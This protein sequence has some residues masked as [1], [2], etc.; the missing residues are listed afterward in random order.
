MQISLKKNIWEA[1]SSA[2]VKWACVNICWLTLKSP[3][4]LGLGTH[5]RS[6]T[7]GA[8]TCYFS[9][10]RC[11]PGLYEQ[12]AEFRNG[13]QVLWSVDMDI[14]STWLLGQIPNSPY[15]WVKSCLLGTWGCA[16]YLLSAVRSLLY[17]RSRD[18]LVKVQEMWNMS[19]LPV[20]PFILCVWF[21]LCYPHMKS[22]RILERKLS[23]FETELFQGIWVI[24]WFIFRLYRA[25]LAGGGVRKNRCASSQVGQELSRV[26]RSLEKLEEENYSTWTHTNL[27]V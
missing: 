2:H 7:W 14:L 19:S 6:P 22:E 21:V 16:F 18:V 3:P 24:E 27:L 13:S 17:L 9:Y 15:Y 23:F 4:W 8:E 26:A 1:E 12:E 25:T 5:S 10:R 20:F 11:L